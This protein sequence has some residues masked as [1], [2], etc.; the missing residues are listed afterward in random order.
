MI[1]NL[2]KPLTEINSQLWLGLGLTLTILGLGL[3]LT[4]TILGLGLAN[5][6]DK[7]EILSQI[8]NVN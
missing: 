4:L 8:T 3:A 6:K 5:I 7:M 2:H 1:E